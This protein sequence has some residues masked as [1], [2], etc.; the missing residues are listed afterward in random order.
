M[1]GP[2]PAD[3]AVKDLYCSCRGV[4]RLFIPRLRAQIRL[5]QIDVERILVE[6]RLCQEKLIVAQSE[7]AQLVQQQLRT[8]AKERKQERVWCFGR[9]KDLMDQTRVNEGRMEE[10][11]DR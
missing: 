10:E 3:N 1:R 6:T 7:Q 2:K 8:L 9:S 4:V 5:Q 11:C